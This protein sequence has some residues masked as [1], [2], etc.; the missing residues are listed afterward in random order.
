MRILVVMAAVGALAG[1]SHG[2]AARRMDSREIA[3]GLLKLEIEAAQLEKVVALRGLEN[4]TFKPGELRGDIHFLTDLLKRVVSHS[5][6]D[7]RLL[8]ATQAGLN[9]VG[10]EYDLVRTEVEATSRGLQSKVHR[11]CEMGVRATRE[12]MAALRRDPGWAEDDVLALNQ[13]LITAEEQRDSV[14]A[15]APWANVMQAGVLAA[16]ISSGALSLTMLIQ[17]GPATLGR[18]I[19]WLRGARAGAATLEFAAVGAGGGV[20]VR[21][22]SSAGALVLTDTEVIALT[23]VGQLSATA[24]SLYMMANGKPPK[25]PDSKAF[26]KW[27]DRSPK[28]PARGRPEPLRYQIKHCGSEETLVEAEGGEKIWADGVRESDSH[29]LEAKHVGSPKRSPYIA[30][31]EAPT[32]VRLKIRSQEA[33]QIRSYAAVIKDP[34]TPAVGLEVITNDA[35][36]ARYFEALMQELGVPGQVVVKP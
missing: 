29:L 21:V 20:G 10:L 4:K 2:E 24:A 14:M 31:S 8:G 15:A 17:K 11:S 6:P 3:T 16:Q 34:K 36:A 1:C 7:P 12:G 18:L 30:E 19:S 28:R 13:V 26:K 25:L 33:A 35:R 27:V 9:I 32:A 22:I 23:Q 5:H